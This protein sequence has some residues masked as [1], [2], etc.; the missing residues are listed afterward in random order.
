MK[1]KIALSIIALQSLALNVYAKPIPEIPAPRELVEVNSEYSEGTVTK[2]TAN[3]VAQFLPWAENAQK[4]LTKSLSDIESMPVDLQ[5]KHLSGVIQSV[6]RRSGQKN[7]QM[8]MR[9]ALNRGTLLVQEL[10]KNADQKEKG[11]LEN[12][13]DIQVKSIRVALDVY[14]SDLSYQKRVAEGKGTIN[15]DYAEFGIKFAKAMLSAV[16]SVFDA[17]AQY[18]LEYKVLEILNWDLSRDASAND[19]ADTIIDIYNTLSVFDENPAGDDRT[20]IVNIRRLNTV[21]ENIKELSSEVV[22]KNYGNFSGRKG[23]RIFEKDEK[24]M[25]EGVTYT[26]LGRNQ[27]GTY[28]VSKT[29]YPYT[30]LNNISGEVMSVTSGCY[31]DICVDDQMYYNNSYYTIKAIS[32]EGNYTIAANVYPYSTVTEVSINKLGKLSGCVQVNSDKICTKDTV[33][34]GTT[35]YQVVA[36]F[37]TKLVAIKGT[38]YPSPSSVVNPKEL[39]ILK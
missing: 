24:V 27:N 20:N 6:V 9:F 5:V 28:A 14:E 22:Y 35:S 36:I 17:S 10:L 26:V 15:L 23:S 19:R 16:N 11:V 29:S 30:T 21:K 13:L 31:S 1:M 8:F 39:T 38:N 18:R 2:L 32:A 34:Y 12:A 7:Y 3:E 33:I 4:V 25:I 37:P